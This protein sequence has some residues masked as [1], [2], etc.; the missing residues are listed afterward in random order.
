MSEHRNIEDTNDDIANKL[1]ID[2]LDFIVRAV[3]LQRIATMPIK[4][5][6]SGETVHVLVAVLPEDLNDPDSATRIWPLAQL[7]D[8]DPFKDLE[9]PA[10]CQLVYVPYASIERILITLNG[11]KMPI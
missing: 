2:T 6:S 8:D 1:A 11:G 7:F 10:N 5:K 9:I 4:L 3:R